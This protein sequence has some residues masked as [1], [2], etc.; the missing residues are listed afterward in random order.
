MKGEILVLYYS[1][2]GATEQLARQVCN[3]VD[4]V[5]GMSARL[6]TVAPV[7]TTTEATDDVIPD[8]GPPYATLQD[9]SDCCGLVMGS[10]T[11]FG[12]MAAAMKYFIDSTGAEWAKGTLEGKPAGV[13]TSTASL[14]GGAET[15]L[16]TMA[17]PLIHHG[18]LYVGMPYSQPDMATTTTGGS[19]YGASHVTWN[20][21][22][23]ELSDEEQRIAQAL[24]ARVAM[25][26]ERLGSG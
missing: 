6:R 18:M 23:D 19:P 4:S 13:F 15:T 26:A 10:A 25:I 7:S 14:H 8:S 21:Q 11:R 2:Y 3:G 22:P 24:G 20:R 9:L 16:L 12:N 17:V 5:A 1:R